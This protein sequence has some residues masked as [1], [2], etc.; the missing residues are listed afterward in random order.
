[1]T[2]P[3]N[4][5]YIPQSYQLL[6]SPDGE[7]VF[8]YNKD[9]ARYIGPVTPRNFCSENYLYTVDGI[10]AKTLGGET[11][12]ES[13]ILAN[14]DRLFVGEMRKIISSNPDKT[15]VDVIHL[16]RFFGYLSCRHPLV[17]SDH[18]VRLN[19]TL[20]ARL[21][22]HAKS[23]PEMRQLAERSGID[24]DNPDEFDKLGFSESRNI[25]IIKMMDQ[26]ER[27]AEHILESMAWRFLFSKTGE[28]I[29]SDNPFVI[30][31]DKQALRGAFE[32]GKDYQIIIP[33]SKE[34]CVAFSA[35][36]APITYE[37]ISEHQVKLL[38]KLVAA[39]AIRWIIG[40]SQHLLHQYDH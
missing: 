40:S 8:L 22:E 25:S 20:I 3:I 10:T 28:F 24:L 6:F 7:K 18:E 5:H 35:D 12:I 15:N 23:S 27:N 19:K 29:L 38:N 13:V 34:V 26:A 21:V 1:M 33:L 9:N 2:A 17:I 36:T 32:N 4:H 30:I 16:A 39:N 11:F 14:L 31:Q 37:Y